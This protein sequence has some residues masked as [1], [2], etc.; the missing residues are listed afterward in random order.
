MAAIDLTNVAAVRAFTQTPEEDVEQ[1]AVTATLITAASRAI[2]AFTEREFAP[3]T[4][5]TAREFLYSGGGFLSLTPHD[6]RT[7]TSV[8]GSADD[9]A[10]W[11][12]IDAFRVVRFP[13]PAPHGVFTG[14]RL[15]GVTWPL[16]RVTGDWGFAA[17]PEDVAQACALTVAIWLRRDVSA[18]S[19]TFNVDTQSLERPESLPS[20]VRGLLSPYKRMA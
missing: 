4:V 12:A 1:D 16:L 5:G 9:G 13:R 20:A 3:A 2:M 7:L 8:E 14:L 19:T 18:F 15:S 17:V 6:L 10:S 11:E